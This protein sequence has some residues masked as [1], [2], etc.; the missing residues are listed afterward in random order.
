MKHQNKSDLKL[1]GSAIYDATNYHFGQYDQAGYPYI[2]HPLRVSNALMHKKDIAY[3][4]VGVLHDIVEDTNF[5]SLMVRKRYGDIIANSVDLLTHD[6]PSISY[7]ERIKMI[8]EDK[9]AKAVK[10]EDLTDNSNILR[11]KGVTDKDFERMKKYH[12]SFIY[13]SNN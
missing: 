2:L 1:L 10:L 4:V 6:D 8:A 9:Y 11:L 12:E 3:P 13:L 7:Q 5:T